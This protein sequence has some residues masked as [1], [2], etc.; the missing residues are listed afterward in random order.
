MVAMV[1]R[2]SLWENL[3]FPVTSRGVTVPAAA[4]IVSASCARCKYGQALY[5]TD[6]NL[7]HTRASAPPL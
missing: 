4:Q 5:S 7:P 6:Y 1:M 2:S 3:P